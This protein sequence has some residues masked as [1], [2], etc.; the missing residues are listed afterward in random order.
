MCF[1]F[2]IL[3][4]DPEDLGSWRWRSWMIRT[5]LTTDLITISL[6]I[7][8]AINKMHLCSL[9]ITYAC[10]Y[11]NP[12]RSTTLTSAN[13]W[14]TPRHK[15]CAVKNSIHPWREYLCTHYRLWAFDHSSCFVQKFFGYPNRLLQQL[16]GGFSETILEVRMLDVGVLGLVWL[17]VACSCAAR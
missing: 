11:H 4:T 16:S 14:P 12:T 9:F 5:T 15:P 2:P 10:P 13:C 17:H 3:C 6:G 7:L 8:T 1:W